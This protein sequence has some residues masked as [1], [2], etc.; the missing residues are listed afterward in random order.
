MSQEKQVFSIDLAGRQLTVETGQ[1]AKQA[2]GA[3]LVRYGDTAVLS[4]ATASKEAKNVDFFPLTVN[5]EER[6]YAVGKIPGGFIKREGRPSEKAILASRLIDRPIRPLFA[7]GFR[8]EVQVVSIVMSVDQDCSSEMAAMLGSSLALSISDIPF[9]GPIAGATVGR[10]NGEF[11]INPTVEQQEQSDIHLVV[12]G[13][14]DA[15][16]MVEAGADQVPEET[17][18]EAIMF[19]HDEIKRLIAF[20]EEIVQAVGKEKSEVKLYE[21]DAD[22]NQAVREMAEEDMHSAIQVH[23]KHAREDAINEV[24]KRVIEHYEAQEADADTLGQ[25]NE[26][27][28]KIVKEEVRRLITVE[29]IRPDGRKGDEIRP[30][31]SEVGI[32]SRTHGSGLFTR[33]QTQALSICTLGALGDVQILD[34]LGVEESKRFMHHYNFPSFSVGETRPMRGPGRREIGHGALGERALEPVIPSEKDFPYTVRLVSEVLE[35]NGSTSQASI[36]G[37][38]LAM[39]DAGVPLK[40]PVAGIA[41]GLVK[42][43]EHYTILSDIQGMEDHLGD[44]D[45][46]VAGTAQGVTA[47]QMDIKIDGL[48]REILEEALQQAKVGRVHILNHMLSVIPEPRTELSAYAPKIITMTI[49]PDKIRDVIGPSG[50]QINKIIEETGVKIDIEQDGTVFISSINQEMN[51]K[52]KKIIE[53]IV[54][55]VQVGE[56]YE[57]KVK[58]VEKFGAFVELFSGKDGLVHIS[59]LALERVGKVEDVVKIG[60]VIT[61]KVIEIDKQGRVNLSRKVLLKEEQEKEEQEKEAAKEENKQEQQ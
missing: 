57:G 38:T 24:K 7:D 2:N 49:N 14:K 13:T 22:L 9:E 51:D 1:L 16:N 3:V 15:I 29:K 41:M 4:T 10:I 52:A 33:G 59:E 21:V 56:I 32:L 25:V 53:D 18:L 26:I 20:Q 19:G 35:S 5:Y 34:G 43:G 45:F 36:C 55:E 11:V 42:T 44:M 54:R 30:L 40:A 46:K 6:L 27:L 31:A 23:E 61:V 39:M 17:M 58:R 50:K 48:S 37:S 28:Y 47:L 8:N 60:D 12:A